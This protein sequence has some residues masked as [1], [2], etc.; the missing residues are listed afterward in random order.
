MNTFHI[1]KYLKKYSQM[2]TPLKAAAWYFICSFFQKSISVLTTPIFTRLL[3]TA[4]YGRYSV[5]NSWLGIVSI[6][7]T[8][9]LYLGVYEQGI[10]KFEK[11]RAVFSSSL[12]GLTLTL[13]AAWTV[14]YVLF[15]D[16][17]NNIF[18][19]TTVQVLAMLIM[20]WTTAVYYFWAA[21]QR[22]IFNYR[23]LVALTVFVSLAK[24]IVGIVFVL[25]AEDKVTARILGLLLVELI[26]YSGLFVVQM[27]R[28]GKFFSAKYWKYCV[29]FN[30]PLIPH[31]LSQAILSSSD[32]IMINDMVGEEKAGIYS[33][34]Y[35]VSM[36]MLLFNTALSQTISPWIM[37]KI[38]DKKIEET[39]PIVYMSLVIIATVNIGLIAFAPEVVAIFAPKS[40]GEAIWVIP[41]VAMSVYFIFSYDVFS[42]IEFYYEKTKLIMLASTIAALA[43]IILNY[44]FIR[45]FGYF[46]AGYTTLLCYMVYAFAHYVFMRRIC[47]SYM[48]GKSVYDSLI[49]LKITI[50]FL[51][52]GFCFLF[53]Y[54]FFVIRCVLIFLLMLIMFIKRKKIIDIIEAVLK[55]RKTHSTN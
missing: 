44:V 6:F 53:V 16:F 33:L 11:E 10:I 32:R 23:K 49:L 3:N 52:L 46:A 48:D 8:L 34:A 30:L 39:E 45:I 12:Q 19:L 51:I 17:W 14:I 55:K 26:A 21:E 13:V 2:P 42:Y 40:Y 20:I 41:P 36:V 18:S 27:K 37:Q 9:R 25:L 29:W 7:T 1:N 28:G 54:K 35:A 5:F 22:V 47:K 24:P 38:K 4:E 50:S 15:R 31:Y 43:N